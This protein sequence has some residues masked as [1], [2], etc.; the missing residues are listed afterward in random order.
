MFKHVIRIARE[1]SSVDLI[2]LENSPNIINRGE[3]VVLSDLN[4]AGFD[5][6]S[7]IYAAVDC[8]GLHIR[9]RWIAFAVRRGR[10]ARVVAGFPVEFQN[11]KTRNDLELVQLR[12]GEFWKGWRDKFPHSKRLTTKADAKRSH[13]TLCEYVKVNQMLGNSVV[14]QVLV[15]ATAVQCFVWKR[16]GSDHKVASNVKTTRAQ[17]ILVTT[18]HGKKC[19]PK[20]MLH[21]RPPLHFSCKDAFNKSYTCLYFY[22]PIR[23]NRSSYTSRRK[24]TINE[25]GAQL[26]HLQCGNHKHSFPEETWQNLIVSSAFVEY[27]MGYPPGY[28]S[29]QPNQRS[30]TASS[31]CRFPSW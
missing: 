16:Q 26:A 18:R 22:T 24:R 12:L 9:R 15:L 6:Y 2:V 23:F 11:L 19:L 27:L 3:Y 17:S 14:P 30:T 7:S 5:V 10:L 29:G 8:M 21:P 4:D 25:L 20:P 31:T 13:G 28:I 1:L